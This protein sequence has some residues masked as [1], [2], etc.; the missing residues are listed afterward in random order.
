MRR[1]Y[2]GG[3]T[4]VIDDQHI[5]NVAK[6]RALKD[7]LREGKK[8]YFCPACFSAYDRTFRLG[9]YCKLDQDG[10]YIPT[11]CLPVDPEIH[12][13]LEAALRLGGIAAVYEL[14]KER[15]G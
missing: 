2:Q 10:S 12:D 5:D 4:L 11:P 1:K 14:V 6:L 13:T 8:W 15:H 7:G 3:A 9:C